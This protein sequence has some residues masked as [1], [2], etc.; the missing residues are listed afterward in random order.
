MIFR[1]YNYNSYKCLSSFIVNLAC[2]QGVLYTGEISLKVVKGK[3]F[4]RF[5]FLFICLLMPCNASEGM[6]LCIGSNGHIAL[7]QNHH[8]DCHHASSIHSVETPQLAQE[9]DIHA[10][11]P[12]CE[13]CIDIP[14]PVGLAKDQHLSNK[15]KDNSLISTFSKSPEIPGDTFISTAAPDSFYSVIVHSDL[16]RTTV[17]LV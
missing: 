12:H 1:Y 2:F 7:E 4:I 6:V 14:V 10:K 3:A 5:F 13:S 17:L 9:L 11:S 15:V 16:L 8:N